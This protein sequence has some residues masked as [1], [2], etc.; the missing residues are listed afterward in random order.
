MLLRAPWHG[1]RE[2]DSE[3]RKRASFGDQEANGG[4]RGL[5]AFEASR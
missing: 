3:V 2:R 4:R 5:E 1:G